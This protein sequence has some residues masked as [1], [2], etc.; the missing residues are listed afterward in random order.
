MF[1]V[2]MGAALAVCVA[3]AFPQ[4]F[5]LMPDRQ[6]QSTDMVQA[7]KLTAAEEPSGDRRAVGYRR[8]GQFT[9][10]ALLN[11][12]NV[13]VLVDTGATSVAINRS[14]ARRIGIRLNDSDFR[15]TATTANGKTKFATA[16]IRKIR[17]DGVVVRNVQAAVLSDHSLNGTL[18]GMSF[19]NKLKTF[20]IK[21]NT[22]TM[23]Q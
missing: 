3:A 23:V 13:R 4:H 6:A 22:L 7:A 17:I 20:E 14:T 10:N 19:L 18:L 8:N 9:F 21:G 16:T 12:R 11:G 2:L 5:G 15:H 1:R